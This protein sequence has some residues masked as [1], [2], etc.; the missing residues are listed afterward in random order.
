MKAN[1][2]YYS[3][4]CNYE[5]SQ[6]KKKNLTIMLVVRQFI[7]ISIENINYIYMKFT[8]WNSLELKAAKT[9]KLLQNPVKY[10]Q[11]TK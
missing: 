11:R 8:S 7:T 6:K 5:F 9:S 1:K 10:L 2:I 3:N 4:I